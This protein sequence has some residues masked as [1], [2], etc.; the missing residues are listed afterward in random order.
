MVKI[1]RFA[2]LFL[3]LAWATKANSAQLTTEN[4]YS[5]NA[6]FVEALYT[7]S[8]A[9]KSPFE[10]NGAL[11]KA[12]SF[13]EIA[14]RVQRD[15]A[16]S[17]FASGENVCLMRA[18][19][20]VC[21]KPV[22]KGDRVGLIFAGHS[23]EFYSTAKNPD[24]FRD[25]LKKFFKNTQAKFIIDFFV[26]EARA[27]SGNF[28]E[29]SLDSLLVYASKYGFDHY[30][31]GIIPKDW[32]RNYTGFRHMNC[33]NIT[34]SRNDVNL[35]FS[36]Q[37]PADV[38]KDTILKGSRYSYAVR[39]GEYGKPKFNCDTDDRREENVGKNGDCS[40]G[41]TFDR[42]SLNNNRMCAPICGLT[43]VL[44]SSSS[45]ILRCLDSRCMAR[46]NQVRR[47]D[48]ARD[49]ATPAKLTALLAAE[50]AAKRDEPEVLRLGTEFV[51]LNSQ[52]DAE[53]S[54]AES[55][56][57]GSQI[58]AKRAFIRSLE[59][60]A[61]E[62][63]RKKEAAISTIR[64]YDNLVHQILQEAMKESVRAKFI[65]GCCADND[66]RARVYDKFKVDLTNP[67]R[68]PRSK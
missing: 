18:S 16:L 26:D 60:Q 47:I 11:D 43:A 67:P 37:S 29:E 36:L 38:T 27:E 19:V 44:T 24:A 5:V 14:E 64:I 51:R 9:R 21:W 63:S 61:R 56:L 66:C 22:F 2:V 20:Q 13:S 45:S 59:S 68:A 54:K 40:P 58:Q 28:D 42:M 53:K 41:Y 32:E 46:D 25:E 6:M 1:T 35:K 17:V 33:A 12:I 30:N 15:P 4:I 57:S 23:K 55:G 50:R 34:Y 48:V 3:G 39:L 31:G 10:V 8:A 62:A 49:L 52:V 7:E 65:S